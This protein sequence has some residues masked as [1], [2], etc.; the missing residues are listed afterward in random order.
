MNEKKFVSHAVELQVFG[1]FFSPYS[2]TGAMFPAEL[3]S[4]LDS[5]FLTSTSAQGGF[6]CCRVAAFSP[7]D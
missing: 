1:L 2:S 5:R 3:A 4:A 6:H 7:A